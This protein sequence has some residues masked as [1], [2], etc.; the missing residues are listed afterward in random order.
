[1]SSRRRVLEAGIFARARLLR[2][3]GG[4]PPAAPRSIF[5]IQPSHIG[6]LLVDT[7]LFEAI[8][9][10]YPGA[11]LILGTGKW[12]FATIQNNPHIHEVI[13]VNCP[14]NNIFVNPKTLRAGFKFVSPASPVIEQLRQR[15]FDL[16][17]DLIGTQF[18]ALLLLNSHIPY[19]IGIKGPGGGFTSFQHHIPDDWYQA[20]AATAL[21]LAQHL[22]VDATELPPINPQIFLTPA[23]I[24]FG[25][26]TWTA[27]ASGR[28][29]VVFGPA[30]SHGEKLWPQESFEKLLL[31]LQDPA[32]DIILVGGHDTVEAADRLAKLVPSARNMVDKLPLRHTFALVST[33]D[34]VISNS[35]M[36]MHAS[37]AFRT[38]S[39]VVLGPMYK[40]AAQHKLQWGYPATIVLGKEA[41]HPELPSAEEVLAHAR[42]LL[43]ARRAEELPAHAG[44]GTAG[45]A[46]PGATPAASAPVR[47]VVWIIQGDEIGGALQA[48]LSLVKAVK[49]RGWRPHVVTL[50]EGP[51]PDACRANGIEVT[52]LSLPLPHPLAGGMV[53]KFFAYRRNNYSQQAIARRLLEIVPAF[54][55]DAIHIQWPTLL[56]AAGTVARQLG[57]P[58]FWEMTTAISDHYPFALNRRAI[59]WQVRRFGIRI[60]ANSRYTASTFGVH[61]TLPTIIYLGVD[62]LRFDPARITPVARAE[63]S[64]P[65]DAVVLGIF[66]RVVRA[67]GQDRVLQAIASLGAAAEPIHLVLLGEIFEPA[68]ADSLRAFAAEKHAADRLHIVGRVPDP[69]RYY[70]ALDFAVNSYTAPESFGLAAVEAMMMER[71]VLTHAAGGPAETVLDGITGWHV[72]DPSVESF[73]AG[74]RSALADRARWREMGIAARRHALE[75]FA[76]GAQAT[77]YM[78]FVEDSIA[79]FPKT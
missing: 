59:R 39:I 69:E 21:R 71:P 40:S 16:G 48:T 15:R 77:R 46:L 1:M 41:D 25:E 32:L 26:E 50:T 8:H 75:H 53:R 43:A 34:L 60:L 6:D 44:P 30:G 38:P 13:E 5:F 27:R 7:P 10:L 72:P 28:K 64:I 52:S 58:C 14:W 79:H 36:L 67:R 31:T 47:T 37:A 49:D 3:M 45:S 33:A 65:S 23:E 11:K 73:A 19:R 24:A 22:G 78:R 66:G 20:M 54:K 35:N 9:R 42:R 63:M 17:I 12:N 29:R 4:L 56:L 70:P 57:V 55:P 2:L 51:L 68:Y 76:I 62:P 61:P 18:D 74:L